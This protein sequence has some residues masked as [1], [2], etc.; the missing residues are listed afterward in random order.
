[1]KL[2]YGRK[3]LG[4]ALIFFADKEGAE[5]A[6]KLD[7][8]TVDGRTIKVDY[9]VPMVKP[10][11]CVSIFLANLPALS[12]EEDIRNIFSEFGDIVSVTFITE[13]QRFKG[14]GFVQFTN[15]EST[16]KVVKRDEEVGFNIHGREIRVSYAFPNCQKETSPND[17]K[18]SWKPSTPKPPGCLTVYVGN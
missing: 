4:K 11:G 16:E 12:T 1:M 2:M 13:G 14:R 5:K 10:E 17:S 6:I 3:F 18:E 15:T 8:T 7:G 9:Y